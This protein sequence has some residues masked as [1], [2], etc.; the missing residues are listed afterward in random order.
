MTPE[1]YRRRAHGL[2]QAGVENLFFWDCY[3]RSD[4][5]RSWTA[6]RRLGHHEEIADWVNAGEPAIRQSGATLHK[7]G[8]WD[9]RY[10]TPG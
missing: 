2:Y 6:L 8:N 4:Y 1:D 3:Q 9:L 7:L 5:S 10:G